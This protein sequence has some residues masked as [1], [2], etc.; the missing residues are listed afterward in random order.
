MAY[1]TAMTADGGNSEVLSRDAAL[2]CLEI[3]HNDQE[4]KDAIQ[5][6]EES[7]G[8]ELVRGFTK[9]MEA[10][11]LCSMFQ[12]QLGGGDPLPAKYTYM[13]K[14][15]PERIQARAEGGD[16]KKDEKKEDA[17]EAEKKEEKKEP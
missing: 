10:A 13:L 9:A 12:I 3:L 5:T 6:Y 7:N 14:Y 1:Q 8:E 4:M 11:G 2:R 17:K 15:T 16:A